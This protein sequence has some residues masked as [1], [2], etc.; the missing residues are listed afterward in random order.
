MAQ[1]NNKKLTLDFPMMPSLP[2][3]GPKIL[4]LYRGSLEIGKLKR[5]LYDGAHFSLTG[6]MNE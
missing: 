6:Y 3:V 4:L 1:Q 5:K 2:L